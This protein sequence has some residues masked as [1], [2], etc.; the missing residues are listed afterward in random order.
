MGVKISFGAPRPLSGDAFKSYP[1]LFVT[2][3]GIAFIM[4]IAYSRELGFYVVGVWCDLIS[5]PERGRGHSHLSCVRI[6]DVP[7][8]YVAGVVIEQHPNNGQI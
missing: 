3:R 1:A 7:H 6:P 4:A 5:A 2:Q 8:A